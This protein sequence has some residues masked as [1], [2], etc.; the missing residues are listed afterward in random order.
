MEIAWS[1]EQP[2]CGRPKFVLVRTLWASVSGGCLIKL[3]S[4]QRKIVLV[5]IVL[6]ILMGLIPPWKEGNAQYDHPLGYRLIV[7]PPELPNYL[8]Q[9]N[10]RIDFGRLILQWI[11][12]AVGVAGECGQS[13]A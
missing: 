3:D 11:L 6:F 5:G 13:T 10:G 8:G 4:L 9:H 12:L 7:A 1:E 2:N